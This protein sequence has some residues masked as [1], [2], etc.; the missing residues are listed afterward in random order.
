MGN[1]LYTIVELAGSKWLVIAECNYKDN[2]FQYVIKVTD[3]EEDFVNEFKVIKSIYKDNQEYC[4]IVTNQDTLKAVMPLLVPMVKQYMDN[5]EKLK[6]L[7]NNL[8]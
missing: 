3:D 4:G 5:P 2:K 8:Q 6:E 7:I 1:E